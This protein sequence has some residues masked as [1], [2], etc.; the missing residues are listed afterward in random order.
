MDKHTRQKL[1][2][3]TPAIKHKE[4]GKLFPNKMVGEDNLKSPL[5]MVTKEPSLNELVI[6]LQR[7]RHHLRED[8]YSLKELKFSKQSLE[9]A[10]ADF[11]QMIRNGERRL[12]QFSELLCDTFLPSYQITSVVVG[13]V[14]SNKQRL[15]FNQNINA[16]EL[17]ATTDIDLGSRQ[18]NKLKYF[19]GQKWSRVDLVANVVDY[20]PTEHNEYA[21]HRIISRIKAEEE[22]W[23]KVVDEIFSFDQLVNEDKQLRHLSRYVKDV[24]GIKIIL[25][26]HSEILKMQ[27]ALLNLRWDEKSLNKFGMEC[28]ENTSGLQLLEVKDYISEGEK[29][30]SGWEAIKYVV[31]WCDKTIEIQ[32]QTLPNFLREREILTK[33]SHLGFKAKRD[34]LR[35]KIAHKIPLFKFYQ[36]LLKWLFLHHNKKPPQYPGVKLSLID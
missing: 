23:N 34:R 27:E 28:N 4:D 24:L 7:L 2:S 35:K 17:Y 6:Q 8:P 26:G 29:K 13:E 11:Y 33:E 1:L 18:L 5:W 16:S 9:K 25:G 14:K 10:R 12:H 32:L 20:Q 21:I 19:D 22:I 3:V 15:T 30:T 31:K 36:D